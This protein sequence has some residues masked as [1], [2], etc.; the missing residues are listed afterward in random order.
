[1]KSIKITELKKY[2]H[3]KSDKELVN[4]IVELFKLS[5]KVKEYYNLKVNPE[6]EQEMLKD[7]KKI[8]E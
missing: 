1:M 5:S 4:E 7:Y 3:M 6:N 8:V 2:L